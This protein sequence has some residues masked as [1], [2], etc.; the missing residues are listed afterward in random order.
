MILV[1]KQLKDFCFFTKM[2]KT[3]KNLAT[4]EHFIKNILEMFYDS[5]PPWF[6]EGNKEG[7]DAQCKT[8]AND[9]SKEWG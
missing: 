7:L 9:Q 4:E 6:I 5:I 1:V 2:R 8:K 3:L